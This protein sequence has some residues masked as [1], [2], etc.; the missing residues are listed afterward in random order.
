[1]NHLKMSQKVAMEALGNCSNNTDLELL[2]SCALKNCSTLFKDVDLCENNSIKNVF[3]YN[4][5][6]YYVI[7]TVSN[8]TVSFF[9]RGIAYAYELNEKTYLKR[10]YP[11]VHGKNFQEFMP[12]HDKVPFPFKCCDNNC[13]T[14]IY[15]SIPQSYLEC[16]VVD[17]AVLTSSEQF[18][19]NPVRLNNDSILGRLNGSIESLSL[20]DNR[21][22]DKITNLVSKFTKQLK[23][24]T[25]KL[26]S[27]RV[28]SEV[29]DLIPNTDPKAKKGSIYYD[30][31]DNVVKVF[32]GSEW[33]TLVF[34]ED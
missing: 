29:V 19:P 7:E 17:N 23:L 15:S 25:S 1:M 9:E 32:N 28:E 11:F 2:G 14:I 10:V 3:G 26:S 8:N 21:L 16:F 13:Y 12:V 24:K 5:N 27:K 18:I 20:D 4:V 30:S 22:V 6:F 33:K 31:I 34:L